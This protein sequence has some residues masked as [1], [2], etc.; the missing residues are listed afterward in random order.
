MQY[1]ALVMVDQSFKKSVE[2]LPFVD[3]YDL[4]AVGGIAQCSE[5]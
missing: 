4:I 1:V 3:I 5:H 2:V